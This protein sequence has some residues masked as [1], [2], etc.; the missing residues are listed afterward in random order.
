MFLTSASRTYFAMF[1]GMVNRQP[2]P[3]IPNFSFLS[4]LLTNTKR[5]P[6]TEW[7]SIKNLGLQANAEVNLFATS[8]FIQ[9]IG[10]Q[11]QGSIRLEIQKYLYEK[12]QNLR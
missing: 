12:L 11:F 9:D 2:S 5:D 10:R 3:F 8:R 6:N 7:L 1:N 4:M